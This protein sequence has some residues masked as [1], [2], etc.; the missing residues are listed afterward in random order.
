MSHGQVQTQSYHGMN[1]RYA[2]QVSASGM[3][4]EPS[5]RRSRSSSKNLLRAGDKPCRK[6]A[7]GTRTNSVSH[8]LR[9]IWA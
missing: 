1:L 5:H 4:F 9:A 2:Q 8:Y 6:Q 3:V 7:D